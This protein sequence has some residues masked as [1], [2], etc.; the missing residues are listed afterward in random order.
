MAQAVALP[1]LRI[2]DTNGDPISGAKAYFYATGTT[3]P[4]TTY[5]NA[6]LTVAHANPVVANSAGVFAPIF[7]DPSLTYRL[8]VKDASDVAIDNW[9]VDPI[10][11][12]ALFTQSATGATSRTV[13]AKLQEFKTLEDFGAVGYNSLGAAAAG[14]DSTTAI[15]AAIDWAYNSGASARCIH[16][17]G[18]FFQCGAITLR[19]STTLLGSGRQTSGFVAK[20]GTTGKWFTAQS[21]QKIVLKDLVFY[22]ADIDTITHVMDLDTGQAGTEGYI[23]GCWFR[24]APEGYGL[25][26]NGNVYYIRNSTFESCLYPLKVLGTSN[27]LSGVTCMQA[28]D[29]ADTPAN[30]IALDLSG[31]AFVRGIH[32]E[33]PATGSIPVR[34]TGDCHLTD[35]MMSLAASTTFSHL[36][37]INTTNYSDWTIDGLQILPNPSTITISNGVLKVGSVYRLGT[38]TI[39]ASGGPYASDSILTSGPPTKEQAFMIRMTNTGGTLQHR[40][41][42]AVDSA[43]AGTFHE[44]IPSASQTLGNTPTGADASTAFATG[45]KI[46]SATPS[47]LILDVADQVK[48]DA[49]VQADIIANSTGTDYAIWPQFTSRDVSGATRIR[50][51]LQLIGKPG[52]TGV[53]WATALGVG[54]LI[55]VQVR[56]RLS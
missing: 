4:Q 31:A 1:V 34:I 23:E 18:N 32:I 21:A 17:T 28:G 36:I 25:Y 33:A 15:Q 26:C 37:E 9:D 7:L 10:S 48:A 3:T 19:N 2:T 52:S 12:S 55:D 43:T 40:I 42:C 47:I 22:A 53:N 44:K 27:Q 16:V 54:Q 8:V 50:L 49:F 46:S 38:S 41:G 30:A 11:S 56:C 35:I 5:S 29:G 20:A 6:A 13:Q 51:E 39:A 14:T 24:N 45:A